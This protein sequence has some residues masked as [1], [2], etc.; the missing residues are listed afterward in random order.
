MKTTLL[1]LSFLLFAFS[2]TSLLVAAGDTLDPVL[3]IDGNELQNGEDVIRVSTALDIVSLNIPLFCRQS[4]LWTLQGVFVTMGG[5]RGNFS[6]NFQIQKYSELGNTYKFVYCVDNVGC[7]DIGPAI[8]NGI[9][10]LTILNDPLQVVF[11][12]A[13]GSQI[14]KITHG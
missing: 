11:V 12:K 1:F 3:D 14:K 6:R 2:T 9:G 4:S 8:M 13:E 5:A 7:R 10:P